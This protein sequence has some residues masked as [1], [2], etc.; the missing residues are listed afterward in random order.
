MVET[1][2]VKWIY[3]G[4][5]ETTHFPFPFPF[6]NVDDV[7]V[8][9]Y[10]I[11][12]ETETPLTSDYFVDSNASEVIY[13]GYPPGEEPPESEQPPVLPDTMK[14][15]IYR[16]TPVDQLE[17]LGQKYP[18]PIIEAMVDKATMILQ[19]LAEKV[20]RAV[21]VDKGD[22]ETPAELK[23]RLLES[24]EAAAASAAAAAESEANAH[25]SELAA[26]ASEE[27]AA[28][29]ESAAAGS[30]SDAADSATLAQ[31]WAESDSS[32]DS[33]EDGDSPT[34]FT[35]SSKTWALASKADALTAE[36]FAE[37]VEG[38]AAPLA[39]D[40]T[41]TYNYPDI[42]AYTDGRTY[43]CI[44]ENVTG[45]EVPGSSAMW[46]SLMYG[47]SAF[48]IDPNGDL[49][50]AVNMLDDSEWEYDSSGDLMP[51]AL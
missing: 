2:V 5:G 14:I 41:E 32:P 48:D 47:L 43:R 13:P 4:D 22:T 10:D 38:I 7:K 40:P 36:A 24:S 6:E 29:S 17:D 50:P 34:G 12:T 45:D 49:M 3:V 9:L 37:Q 39:W 20:S 11:P 8:S 46:V 16:D 23:E 15:V 1:S 28:E 21:T 42:V 51:I 31:K 33:E 27:N 26:A 18:L 30:A 25:E 19:E 44:G 35:Q